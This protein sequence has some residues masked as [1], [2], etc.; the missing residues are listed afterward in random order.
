VTIKKGKVTSPQAAAPA[1]FKG[2]PVK[3]QGLGWIPDL[4]DNR[5][6]WFAVPANVQAN[7]GHNVDLREQ[8]PADVYNQGRVGS[9]T[10]NAVAGLLEFQMM[11]QGMEEVF[12]PSRLFI[13]YNT[14]LRD[15]LPVS[16][17]TGSSI[18]NAFKS[19]ATE[20]LCP[21]TD[22]PYDDTPTVGQNGPFPAGARAGMQPSKSCYDNAEQHKNLAYR[23][24]DQTLADMK[25]C[26]SFGYPFA[27][28]F[29]VYESFYSEA[30]ARGADRGMVSMPRSGERAL[31]GHAV[32]AVGFDDEDQRFIVR[33][34]WGEEWG[35]AGYF[36]LPYSYMIDDDLATDFW[37]LSLIQ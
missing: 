18:R 26:L 13:Y 28:G 9:C 34:S 30:V 11:K 27:F 6:Q 16:H 5:D 29:T 31:G 7:L 21:E 14:R 3:I 12:T 35:D 22:W 2:T 36:Y 20:G 25:G 8:L 4:P 19:I 23:R 33:N 24:V 37:M 10:A 1:G 17:D 32:L 15:S